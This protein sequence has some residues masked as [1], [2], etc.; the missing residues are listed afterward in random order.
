MVLHSGCTISTIS[1]NLTFL[2]IAVSHPTGLLMRADI[3]F[4]VYVMYLFYHETFFSGLKKQ[5]IVQDGRMYG[6]IFKNNQLHRKVVECSLLVSS[7]PF[8]KASQGSPAS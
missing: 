8:R 2:T 7:M 3:F 5:D 4:V 1:R 6:I